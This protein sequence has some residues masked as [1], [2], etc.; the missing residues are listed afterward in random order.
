MKT[1]FFLFL[2]HAFQLFW[3]PPQNQLI[4]LDIASYGSQSKGAKIVIVC[5]GNNWNLIHACMLHYLRFQQSG[6]DSTWSSNC[7]T[8]TE[9]NIVHGLSNITHDLR[10]YKYSQFKFFRKKNL[11][12]KSSYAS[13]GFKTIFD[14]VGRKGDMKTF[15]GHR[16]HP[17]AKCLKFYLYEKQE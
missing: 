7:K 3:L 1:R 16:R 11:M 6:V 17:T 4:V 5:F 13:T 9:K 8:A 10:G 2:A 15:V 14:T 12:K